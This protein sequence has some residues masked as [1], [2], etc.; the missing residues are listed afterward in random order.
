MATAAMAANPCGAAIAAAARPIAVCQA[1][2]RAPAARWPALSSAT[3][4]K[5]NNPAGSAPGNNSCAGQ[6]TP[7]AYL[8]QRRYRD[9]EQRRA[10]EQR[11][12]PEA[13]DLLCDAGR[14]GSR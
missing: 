11:G 8:Q 6:R 13:T 12:A 10:A 7:P 5:C 14:S 1:R 2:N 9:R 3:A 4:R